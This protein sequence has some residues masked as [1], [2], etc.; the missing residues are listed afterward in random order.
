MSEKAFI[1]YSTKYE[2]GQGLYVKFSNVN[3]RGA[4]V[5][6]FLVLNATNA[7]LSLFQGTEKV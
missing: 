2:I 4:T 7:K 6:D 3:I 1:R 5:S